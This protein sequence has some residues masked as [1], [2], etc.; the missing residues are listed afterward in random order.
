MSNSKKFNRKNIRGLILDMDGV[1]WL[2]STPIGNLSEIFDVI[3][4]KG[5]RFIMATNN[6][7]RASHQYVEKLAGFGVQ[8]EPW[9]VIGS[10]DATAN[11]LKNR[12]PDGG[13]IYAIGEQPLISTLK[14]E[15]FTHGSKNP[16]AV[17]VA[18][19]RGINYEKL[20]EATLLL[21][22]GIPFIGTN[23]DRSYPIPEG[24]APGAGAILAA[25]EAASE[26]QPT[27]M[28]KPKPHLYKLALE[29]LGTSPA[30]TLVIGDRLETDILG[31][32]R[33]GC[34]AALVLTGVATAQ[35]AEKWS[36]P[37]DFIADDLF[38]LIKS[39]PTNVP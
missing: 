11:Y 20:T 8:V 3:K 14:E 17:V 6:A 18:L 32:Q 28:G 33:V 30:E 15:G 35:E 24:Q 37:L 19:D 29:R 13:E 1:L 2:D 12:F 16:L 31:A 26:I 34:L 10:A 4:K 9:Q 21:R 27:V 23:P 39:L 5:F 38:H 25:L 36:P 22:R 7:S